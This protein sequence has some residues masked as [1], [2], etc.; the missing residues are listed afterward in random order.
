MP[1]RK[2]ISTDI[3]QFDAILELVPED[4]RVIAEKLVKELVFMAKTLDELKEAI[5]ENGAMCINREGNLR[6]NP[7]LK[8]Y[9]VLV[10]RY[11]AIYKQ[12][13]DLMPK[14][15]EKGAESQLMDFIKQG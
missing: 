6:D 1:R 8:V 4:R 9:T 2:E 3:R 15:P 5:K 11:S 14:A 10:P 12:L 13:T 7:A